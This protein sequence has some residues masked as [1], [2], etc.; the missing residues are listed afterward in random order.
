MAFTQAGLQAANRLELD[1]GTGAGEIGGGHTDTIRE[2]RLSTRERLPGQPPPFFSVA[3]CNHQRAGASPADFLI[4]V[5][6]VPDID[7]AHLEIKV[8]DV[9]IASEEMLTRAT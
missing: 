4:A 5:R 8:G 2:R 6:A 1:W 3:V 9:N 7:V